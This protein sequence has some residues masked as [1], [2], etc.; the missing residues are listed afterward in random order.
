M[1]REW[2]WQIDVGSYLVRV[3]FVSAYLPSKHL[4]NIIITMS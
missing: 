3:A 2:I 4:K 1:A